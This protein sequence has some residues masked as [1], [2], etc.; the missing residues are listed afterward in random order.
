MVVVVDLVVEVLA[1]W[2]LPPLHAAVR[3]QTPPTASAAISRRMCSAPIPAVP[4]PISSAGY[5]DSGA[6]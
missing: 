3:M 6:G 4:Q 2:L 1:P 5:P